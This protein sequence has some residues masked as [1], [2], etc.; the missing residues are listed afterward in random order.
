MRAL[1]PDRLSH[2]ARAAI[3]AASAVALLVQLL[4]MASGSAARAASPARS[5]FAFICSHDGATDASA[6]DVA[7]GLRYAYDFDNDGTYD[8]GGTTYATATTAGSSPS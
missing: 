6:A 2:A 3:A 1:R 7:A 8:T 4:T 5:L